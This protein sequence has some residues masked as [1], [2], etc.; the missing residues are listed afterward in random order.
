MYTEFPWRKLPRSRMHTIIPKLS[1]PQAYWT[2]IPPLEKKK[3][4]E[5]ILS[6][7]QKSFFW[8][9]RQPDEIFQGE[10]LSVW[11]YR[12]RV[13]TLFKYLFKWLK[14]IKQYET[15]TQVFKTK[16][17]LCNVNPLWCYGRQFP[18]TG[19]SLNR[20]FTLTHYSPVSLFY[21]S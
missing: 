18:F 21:T 11:Y 15:E 4:F 17:L 1:S 5:E 9:K 20:Q 19:D 2:F 14:F 7:H 13:L 6:H 12:K 3:Q 10:T 8:G 16:E